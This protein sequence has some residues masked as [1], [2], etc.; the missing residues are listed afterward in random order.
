MCLPDTIGQPSL[1]H[2]T[3]FAL[4]HLAYIDIPIFFVSVPNYDW[5]LVSLCIADVAGMLLVVL[6]AVP[7]DCV[8]LT[9]EVGN[10]RVV[11][12]ADD[13]VASCPIK[14]LQQSSLQP[15]HGYCASRTQRKLVQGH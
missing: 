8:S 6:H 4:R 12:E 10:P 5:E 11:I 9:L 7:L 3:N 13:F 2:S 15:E 1:R 14:G